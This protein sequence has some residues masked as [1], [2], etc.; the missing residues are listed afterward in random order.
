MAEKLCL[1]MFSSYDNMIYGQTTGAG[2]VPLRLPAKRTLQQRLEQMLRLALGFSSNLSSVDDHSASHS[3]Q[4]LRKLLE[5]LDSSLNDRECLATRI[6]SKKSIP[7][8]PCKGGLMVW[9]LS[10]MTTN[11]QD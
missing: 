8:F 3:S 4:I 9:F 2:T 6:T 7:L 10:N 5:E 1:G 11:Q